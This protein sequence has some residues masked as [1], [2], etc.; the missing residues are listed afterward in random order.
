MA[1]LGL[2]G[3]T[4]GLVQAPGRPVRAHSPEATSI[5]VTGASEREPGTR[6][7]EEETPRPTHTCTLRYWSFLS[8]TFGA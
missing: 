3:W 4:P 2:A 5:L 6:R 8:S 7:L 1:L